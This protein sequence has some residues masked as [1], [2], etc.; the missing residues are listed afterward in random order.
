M[1]DGRY[2]PYDR[3]RLPGRTH[4]HGLGGKT[5]AACHSCNT[6]TPADG[7]TGRLVDDMDGGLGDPRVPSARD[8]PHHA[9]PWL[10]R[11][12]RVLP[13]DASPDRTLTPEVRP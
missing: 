10:P 9:L 8:H 3:P 12:A 11:A 7:L 6:P 1:D 5:S 2:L 13:A 4:Q